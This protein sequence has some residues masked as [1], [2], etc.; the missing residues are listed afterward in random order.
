MTT[1]EAALAEMSRLIYRG[2]T[3]RASF[4]TFIHGLPISQGSMKHVGRGHLVHSRPLLEWRNRI[5]AESVEAARVAGFPLNWDGP[6]IVV[7]GFV[8]PRPKRPR[9]A[10]PA[11][12]PDLDKLERAVGDALSLGR[13]A[14]LSEDSRIIEWSAAKVYARPGLDTGLALRVFAV[15][16][17]QE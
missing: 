11:T 2:V 14:V 3:M 6:A 9:F 13:G 17:S 5:A 12:K 16:S 4:E 7:A 15:E 1:D 10:V 8:L